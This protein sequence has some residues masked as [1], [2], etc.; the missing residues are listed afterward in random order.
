M[1]ARLHRPGV[2]D[3]PLLAFVL[4]CCIL[5][6]I[7][8]QWQPGGR[9]DPNA[10]SFLNYTPWLRAVYGSNFIVAAV[11]GIYVLG[12]MAITAV[13]VND[14]ESDH[15]ALT[16]TCWS[17]L[18]L[19][20]HFLLAVVTIA[21]VHLLLILL[22]FPRTTD[23]YRAPR[24][25]VSRAWAAVLAIIA[26]FIGLTSIRNV[27]GWYMVELDVA[28]VLMMIGSLLLVVAQCFTCPSLPYDPAYEGPLNH[29]TLSRVRIVNSYL[30]VTLMLLMFVTDLLRSLEIPNVMEQYSLLINGLLSALVCMELTDS[31]AIIAFWPRKSTQDDEYELMDNK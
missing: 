15:E 18:V 20:G 25:P 17:H 4:F 13:R 10:N 16:A 21:A 22:F 12:E 31:A 8:Y 11:T 24:S 1:I 30:M 2:D 19:W 9:L 29:P 3:M 7:E 6:L 5:P 28:M 26:F 27:T 14:L 23:E